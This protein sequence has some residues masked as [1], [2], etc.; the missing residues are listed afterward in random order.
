MCMD[1]CPLYFQDSQEDWKK[2]AA[3]MKRIYTNAI[4]TV[5]SPASDPQQP[6]FVER[7]AL[8][9]R[10]ARLQLQSSDGSHSAIVNLHPVLPKWY[11]K[12]TLNFHE[13]GQ[14]DLKASLPASKRAWCLQE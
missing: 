11:V 5:V 6:L 1:R 2:E 9:T 10:P 7:D 3:T 14:H 4:C 8:V 12:T 13:V